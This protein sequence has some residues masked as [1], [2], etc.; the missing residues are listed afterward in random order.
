M[1]GEMKKRPLAKAKAKRGRP[2]L[3]TP[4]LTEEICEL[5]ADGNTIA[6]SCESLNVGVPTY[7]EWRQ[8]NP[9]FMD[10]TTRA[11]GKSTN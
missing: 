11:E 8:K 6:A 4:A 5:L 9:D 2:T 1:S 7:H 3:C 10:A